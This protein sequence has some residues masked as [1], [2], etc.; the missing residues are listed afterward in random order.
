MGIVPIGFRSQ[1][2]DF[3]RIFRKSYNQPAFRP[4]ELHGKVLKS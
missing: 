1:A 2:E 3:E 4:S